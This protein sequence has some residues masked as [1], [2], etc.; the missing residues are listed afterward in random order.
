LHETS[1]L[2]SRGFVFLLALLLWF[3]IDLL[4]IDA[5]M[6]SRSARTES[7]KNLKPMRA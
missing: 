6:T 3:M 7:I 4:V 2:A 5:N 1:W